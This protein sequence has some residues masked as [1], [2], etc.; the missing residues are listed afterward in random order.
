MTSSFLRDKYN[1]VEALLMEKKKYE[2][3]ERQIARKIS[4]IERKLSKG[5][6]SSPHRHSASQGSSR[7]TYNKDAARARI[8]AKS[9]QILRDKELNKI[10]PSK[11]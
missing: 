10:H 3:E 9:A 4:Q 6:S 2:L 5:K 8:R 1:T 11:R 7:Q